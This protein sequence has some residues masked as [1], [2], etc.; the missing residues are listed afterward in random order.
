MP[1]RA[2]A[3]QE[4]GAAATKAGPPPPCGALASTAPSLLLVSPTRQR[5]RG[6]DHPTRRRR[7]FVNHSGRRGGS[8]PG[9]QAG[10]RWV[11]ADVRGGAAG[12]GAGYFRVTGASALGQEG[13]GAGQE[14]TPPPPTPPRGCIDPSLRA[15]AAVM[16]P[17]E[18]TH[19]GSSWTQWVGQPWVDPW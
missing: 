3:P 5:P 16:L 6:P 4:L 10:P 11:R 1:S 7:C 14:G 17:L 18:P 15:S 9:G 12:R 2:S 8:G 19:W 13:A